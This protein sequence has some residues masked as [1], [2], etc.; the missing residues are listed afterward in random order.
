MEEAK[1]IEK[2]DEPTD[3]VN[4]LV[5]VRKKGVLRVCLDPRDLNREIKR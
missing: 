2:I 4:S 3:C 1:I 5:V